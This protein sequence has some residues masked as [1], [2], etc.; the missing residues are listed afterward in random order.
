VVLGAYSAR[1]YQRV[2]CYNVRI[3]PR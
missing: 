3:V 2:R 1:P